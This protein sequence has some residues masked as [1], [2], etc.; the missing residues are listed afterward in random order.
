[1]SVLGLAG[2]LEAIEL[3]WALVTE[4]VLE[5]QTQFL[6]Q[7]HLPPLFLKLHPFFRRIFLALAEAEERPEADDDPA[8]GNA[9]QG[10]VAFHESGEPEVRFQQAE[11]EEEG[12]EGAEDDDVEE[13]VGTEG[14]EA[15]VTGGVVVGGAAAAAAVGAGGGWT[16]AEAGGRVGAAGDVVA[17][18][19]VGGG[20][21]EGDRVG[22]QVGRDGSAV[23]AAVAV[24]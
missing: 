22:R 14:A 23:Y 3:G 7:A 11:K 17:V 19:E 2:V 1:M 18:G 21:A 9:A 8:E 16:S 10:G 12:N 5:P 13:P 6:A 20:G 4:A 24:G 15:L